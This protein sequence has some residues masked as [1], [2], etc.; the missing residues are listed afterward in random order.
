M[1]GRKPTVPDVDI[2]REIAV[3]P[4]PIVT[5]VELADEIDMSQQGAYSRLE[6]LESEE[7]VRSKKVGSRARVWWITDKGRQQL[8]DLE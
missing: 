8:A 6:T 5:A 1:T 7:Y 4:D 3:A 2:L